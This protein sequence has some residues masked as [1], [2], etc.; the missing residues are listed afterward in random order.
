MHTNEKKTENIC[1]YDVNKKSVTKKVSIKPATIKTKY[2][3][4]TSLVLVGIKLPATLF[5]ITF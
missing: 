3:K 4:A 2:L 1:M 5:S